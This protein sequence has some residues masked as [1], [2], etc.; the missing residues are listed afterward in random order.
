MDLKK[1]G[2]LLS[3]EPG[4]RIKQIERSI[5]KDFCENWNEFTGLPLLLRE[6]LKKEVDLTINGIM[7][8]SRD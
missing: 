6:A 5:Y 7:H 8:Q 1:L 2:F 4:F 3:A